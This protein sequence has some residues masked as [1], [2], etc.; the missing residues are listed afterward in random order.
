MQTMLANL[1]PLLRL[2][3]HFELPPECADEGPRPGLK[4]EMRTMS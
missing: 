2:G 3:Y 1:S 4:H